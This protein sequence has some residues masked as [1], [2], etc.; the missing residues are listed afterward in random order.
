MNVID[1]LEMYSK[2]HSLIQKMYSKRHS[3]YS[4]SHINMLMIRCKSLI[5]NAYLVK[6]KS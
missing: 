5:T 1:L 4:K 6:I 3:M 2:S